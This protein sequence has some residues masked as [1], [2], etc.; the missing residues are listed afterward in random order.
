MHSD[1]SQ[2]VLALSLEYSGLDLIDNVIS[3][4]S[5]AT[6]GS[7]CFLG[8]L[9]D[10]NE[11][12]VLGC[13]AHEGEIFK[14]PFEYCMKDQ[15]CRLIYDDHILKI[16]CDVQRNFER[17]KGTGLESFMGFPLPHPSAGIIGHIAAY[18]NAPEVFEQISTGTISLIQ[19][20][21]SRE[22]VALLK[23]FETT[24]YKDI[25]KELN[26]WR[27][28]ALLDKLTGAKNRRALEETW[29]ARMKT[30]EDAPF[31]LAILDIDHFKA[32]NDTYGHDIGDDC[33]K[34]FSSFLQGIE[35]TNSAH[36]FRLG[37]EE[38]CIFGDGVDH[39]DLK[40]IISDWHQKFTTFLQEKG[41]NPAFTF[42]G[43][44]AD[45]KIKDFASMLKSADNR[46]YSAK[47][48]GRNRIC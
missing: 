31:S 46:L 27:D 45:S 13:L 7:F 5:K 10:L 43:G 37:G 11:E 39:V 28:A 9:K 4:I 8:F 33:L 23:E 34:E 32:I 12:T 48:S 15:P 30:I 17:K 3:E 18:H 16:P 1:L 19:S 14:A 41:Y 21:L 22:V 2:R 47:S 26:I 42:S 20:I 40:N 6:D 29:H 44:V 35:T 24:S 38:F 25:Q 36:F